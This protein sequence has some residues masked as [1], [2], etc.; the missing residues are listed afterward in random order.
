MSRPH[1]EALSGPDRGLIDRLRDE[2]RRA[3]D[4][5]RAASQQAYMK[6]DL[7]YFGLTAPDLKLLLRPHLAGYA[8]ATRGEW[9]AMIR[10]LWDEA[11]HREEWYV[12]LALARHRVAV[13]WRDVASMQLWRHLVVTG[14]W[15]DVVDVIAA[16]L[17]GDA[18]R[19]HRLDVTPIVRAW[20]TDDDMWLRRTSVLAQL[21]HRADTDLLLLAHVIERNLDD[22]SFW[23]RKSIGWALREQARTNPNWVR[24]QV[25]GWGDRLSPL[26]RR[27]AT[28]HL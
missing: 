16:H 21:G 5:I 25:V 17:V 10:A 2:M 24:A 28:K 11:T 23:L 18:L 13:D 9:E 27:E 14:A 15:W 12:A 8:P 22:P 4:P 7:P 3:G 6:S 20:A 1:D 19:L 26:S